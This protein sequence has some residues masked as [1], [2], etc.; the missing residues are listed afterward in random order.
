MPLNLGSP[1]W[2]SALSG[3]DTQGVLLEA[4]LV[5]LVRCAPVCTLGSSVQVAPP[6]HATARAQSPARPACCMSHM[7]MNV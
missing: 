1:G 7:L 4:G 5:C 6:R 3:R 2:G